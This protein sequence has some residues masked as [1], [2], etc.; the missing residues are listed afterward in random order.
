MRYRLRRADCM[1]ARLTKTLDVFI[2]RLAWLGIAML[3][4]AV[5]VTVVDVLGRKLLGF[6]IEGTVEITQLMVMYAAFTAIPYAFTSR[7]HVAISLFIDK[8]PLFWRRLSDLAM[9]VLAAG[10]MMAVAWFG[11]LKGLQEWEYGDVTLTLGI[12]KIHFWLP[13]VF[14]SAISTL[15]L[16]LRAI[17]N[18]WGQSGT[19]GMATPGAATAIKTAR[20]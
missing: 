14:G 17:E 7:S 2:G 1:L 18:L 15:W 20:P 6:S 4:V 19:P 8:L 9:F 11:A 12:P 16:V 5:L 10:F 13:L 3:C